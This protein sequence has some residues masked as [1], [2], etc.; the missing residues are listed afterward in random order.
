MGLKTNAF[1]IASAPF[2]LISKVNI[3]IN[4]VMHEQ[5]L[6][7]EQSCL[8]LLHLDYHNH[9]QLNCLLMHDLEKQFQMGTS[10]LLKFLL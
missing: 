1:A 6:D 8:V 4:L 3:S 2:K 5:L 7:Q 9:E 10:K